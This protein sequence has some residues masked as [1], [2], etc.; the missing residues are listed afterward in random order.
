[1]MLYDQ[2]FDRFVH[3]SHWNTAIAI[4]RTAVTAVN[5]APLHRCFSG[6]NSC[7][8]VFVVRC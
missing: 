6:L 3:H 2:L 5:V 1:M 4:A 8:S 7:S